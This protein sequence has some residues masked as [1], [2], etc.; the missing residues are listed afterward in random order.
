MCDGDNVGNNEVNV[1]GDNGGNN[2]VNVGGGDNGGFYRYTLY[3][4]YFKL[5]DFA[6]PIGMRSAVCACAICA[7]LHVCVSCVCSVTL[8][9]GALQQGRGR[10]GDMSPTLKSRGPPICI[11]SP[12]PLLTQ[13][14]Y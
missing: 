4:H 13:H 12:P 5:D 8:P 14:L 7:L 3:V 10:G 11:D 2:E 6:S 1:G 9:V